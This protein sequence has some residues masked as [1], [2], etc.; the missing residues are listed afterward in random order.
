MIVQVQMQDAFNARAQTAAERLRDELTKA[1]VAFRSI[2]VR[3]AQINVA[4]INQSSSFQAIV[5]Q[6]LPQWSAA[7]NGPADFVLKL[8]PA[9][10]MSLRRD[11][12]AQAR[13]VME[14]LRAIVE[15]AG[16][17]L[18][19]AIK[20]TCYVKDLGDFAA[21]NEVYG[22]YFPN[23]PPARSTVQ[24]ARLP[25]DALVE[26]ELVVAVPSV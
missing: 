13:Q 19:Q 12:Y 3:Q 16:S 4:G 8:K 24:V 26:V 21:F 10:A 7:T 1:S 22:T 14:N 17:S 9:D 2:D 6:Q 23:N 25:V 20:S 5:A 11:I 18:D 15:A